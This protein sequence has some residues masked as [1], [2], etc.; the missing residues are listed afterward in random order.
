[1]IA[2]EPLSQGFQAAKFHYSCLVMDSTWKK[3][4]KNTVLNQIVALKASQPTPPMKP[5]KPSRVSRLR[6]FAKFQEKSALL[7]GGI[8]IGALI[9]LM[10]ALRLFKNRT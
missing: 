7:Y 2:D 5:I 8:A 10:V 1:V 3:P 4:T 6:P 9:V